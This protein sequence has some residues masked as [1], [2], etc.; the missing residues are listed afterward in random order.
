MWLNS[1]STVV[2]GHWRDFTS[3]GAIQA[4]HFQQ[5]GGQIVIQHCR[6]HGPGGKILACVVKCSECSAPVSALVCKCAEA[7]MSEILVAT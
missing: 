2:A 1:T 5:T 7:Q 6:A 4:D 3:G